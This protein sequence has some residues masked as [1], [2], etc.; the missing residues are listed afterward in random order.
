MDTEKIIMGLI[1]N[2]GDTKNHMYKALSY[3]KEK[4]YKK[5]DEE[6]ELAE[7]ALNKAHTVQTEFLQSEAGGES[8]DI[9]ALFVHAQDHLMTSMTE[10]TLI[11]EIIDLQ[12]E[13]HQIQNK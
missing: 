7:E 2:S 5:A 8:T 9:S 12:K 3:V 1:L 6:I 10:V 4:D 13:I 11:K